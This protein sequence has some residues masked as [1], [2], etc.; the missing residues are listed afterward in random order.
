MSS[1]REEEYMNMDKHK[2]ERHARGK[3]AQRG[4]EVGIEYKNVTKTVN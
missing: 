2:G 1:S 3:K 4:R